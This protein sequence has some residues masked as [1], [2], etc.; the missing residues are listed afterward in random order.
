MFGCLGFIV[1]PLAVWLLWGTPQTVALKVAFAALAAHLWG[2]G[3][4]ENFREDPQR[5]PNYAA[6][7]S[8]GSLVTSAVLVI[9][10]LAN[11]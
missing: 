3:I 10:A 1:A 5:M 8:M 6:W 11:R 7:L 4:A 9:Y 2:Y